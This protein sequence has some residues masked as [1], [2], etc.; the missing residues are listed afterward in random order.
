MM[1]MT[2]GGT[3]TAR[4]V[5]TQHEQVHNANT[6]QVQHKIPRT[7]TGIL[8]GICSELTPVATAQ[9]YWN[10]T[11]PDRRQRRRSM[12]Q[13]DTPWRRTVRSCA[14]WCKSCPWGRRSSLA[15]RAKSYDLCT[16]AYL[17]TVTGV[18][19]INTSTRPFLI[20]WRVDRRWREPTLDCRWLAGAVVTASPIGWLSMTI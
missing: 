5:K 11:A 16:T 17:S 6:K 15:S 14:E 13:K 2:L 10:S 3:L 18:T 8:S 19:K 20:I 1:M 12:T 4:T 7:G 9:P